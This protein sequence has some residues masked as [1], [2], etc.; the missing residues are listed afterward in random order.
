MSHLCASGYIA[1]SLF[2]AESTCKEADGCRVIIP[3]TGNL[4]TCL[5]TFLSQNCL[6][7]GNNNLHRNK[8]LIQC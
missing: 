6:R 8:V 3:F 5:G 1:D 4:L 7:I 2:Y